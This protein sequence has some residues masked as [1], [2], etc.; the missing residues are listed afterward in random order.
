MILSICQQ[1]TSS[2]HH[3]IVYSGPTTPNNPH[4][5]RLNDLYLKNLFFFL[6]NGL[7]CSSD[8]TTSYDV[9]IVLS[10]ANIH[11]YEESFNRYS[12]YDHYDYYSLCMKMI[13][14][15]YIFIF[16]HSRVI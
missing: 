14:Y 7:Q 15:I 5:I 2:L 4:T 6:N 1:G 9:V 10:E 16:I 8:P 12:M 11:T 13:I 3:L